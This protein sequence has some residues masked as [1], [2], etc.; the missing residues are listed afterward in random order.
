M[1]DPR[2]FIGGHFIVAPGNDVLG[3]GS[4]A[5]LRD[6]YRLYAFTAPDIGCGYDTDLCDPRV[7]VHQG[8]DLGGP[9]LEPTS[10]DHPLDTVDHK[11]IPVLVIIAQI[12]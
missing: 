8:F 4:L 12:T 11:E 10:V 7:F 6:H 5:G 9:Y 1:H 3:R 2:A